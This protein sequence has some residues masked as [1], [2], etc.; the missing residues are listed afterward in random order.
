MLFQSRLARGAAPEGA[1][2]PLDIQLDAIGFKA[3][4][5]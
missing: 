4:A 3:G 2:A 1:A 5:S